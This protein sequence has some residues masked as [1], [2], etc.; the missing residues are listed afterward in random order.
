MLLFR[1]FSFS[2]GNRGEKCAELLPEIVFKGAFKSVEVKA[3]ALGN[4]SFI[5]SMAIEDNVGYE[6]ANLLLVELVC[7]SALPAES[8]GIFRVQHVPKTLLSIRAKHVI[9]AVA[10]A[11][12]KIEE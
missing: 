6:G 9:Y 5:L 7:F 8:L 1:F 10:S 3:D 2:E 11:C 4:A 12:R